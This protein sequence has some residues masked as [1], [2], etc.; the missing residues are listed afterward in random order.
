MFRIVNLLVISILSVLE[1]GC[2]TN[3]AETQESSFKDI[4]FVNEFMASNSS[5]IA[6]NAG[7][8]DDWIELYNKGNSDVNLSGMYLT[9][10]ISKPTKWKI[11]DTTI[12]AGGFLLFWADTEVTE[13]KLHTNFK[14]S[15]SGEQI[16]LFDTDANKNFLIDSVSFS[17]QKKDTSYGRSSDGENNWQFFSTPTPKATNSTGK[18]SGK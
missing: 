16:G 11:P 18:K 13:G 17:L 5:I 8:Y 7:D 6:D 1:G 9:D 14:L 15:A 3:P 2:R 10:D 12:I 4:L